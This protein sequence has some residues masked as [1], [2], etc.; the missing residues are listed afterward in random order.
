[1]EP[2][3]IMGEGTQLATIR[4]TREELWLWSLAPF[5]VLSAALINFENNL[6][7]LS[8]EPWE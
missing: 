3:Y 8:G 5:Q 7:L 1:V 6:M 2:V 4:F